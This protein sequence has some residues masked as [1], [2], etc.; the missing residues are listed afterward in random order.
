MVGV[1]R[2]GGKRKATQPRPVS[3][4]TSVKAAGKKNEELSASSSSDDSESSD[5][6]CICDKP[7]NCM[8]Y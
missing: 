3:K 6:I 4:K 1:K 8:F 5:S 2:R 7:M